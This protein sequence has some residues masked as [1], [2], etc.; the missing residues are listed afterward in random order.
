MDCSSYICKKIKFASHWHWHW[1]TP[2]CSATSSLTPHFFNIHLSKSSIFQLNHSDGEKSLPICLV[3]WPGLL[4]WMSFRL[5][6]YLFQFSDLFF[7]HHSLRHTVSLLHTLTTSTNY[8]FNEQFQQLPHQ[9]KTFE[10]DYTL[11]GNNLNLRW[12]I[13][14]STGFGLCNKIKAWSAVFLSDIA[15]QMVW[16]YYLLHSRGILVKLVMRPI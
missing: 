15:A 2:R 8:V 11:G 3:Y 1:L 16:T 9:N 13:L 10:S 5:T 7:T 12:A 14:V 6:A 4:G